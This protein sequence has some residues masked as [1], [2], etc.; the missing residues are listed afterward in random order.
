MA[1]TCEALAALR[2]SIGL[3]AAVQASVLGERTARGESRLAFHAQVGFLAG[4]RAHVDIQLSFFSE[5]LGTLGACVRSLTAV[6]SLMYC[7]LSGI[8][9]FLV[10]DNAREGT[11]TGVRE[12]MAAQGEFTVETR[13]TYRTGKRFLPRMNESMPSEVLLQSEHFAA[14]ATR[15][16]VRVIRHVRPERE[17]CR[18]GISGCAP[19]CGCSPIARKDN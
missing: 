9:E 6:S 19:V 8:G 18:P 16:D 2:A 14:I 5:S 17:G 12:C 4:M 1:E 13:E 3:L 10:A 11:L 7:E 15:I